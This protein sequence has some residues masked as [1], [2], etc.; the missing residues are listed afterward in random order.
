[1]S[2]LRPV[3]RAA[4][5]VLGFVALVSGVAGGLVRVGVEVPA[6]SAGIALHGTLLASA[7]FGT[8]ISLERAVA[9]GRLWAYAAPAASGIG[10]VAILFGQRPVGLAL[11]GLAGATFAA[12][13]GLIWLRQRAL[14]TGA[15]AVGALGLL[16]ANLAIAA[17]APLEVPVLGWLAFFALTIGGERLELSRLAP[18]PQGARAL[19]AAAAAALLAAALGAWVAPRAAAHATGAL[20]FVMA[21]WLL[22]YDI[23]TRTVHAAGLTRYIALC[24][25][26]GYAWLALGAVTLAATGGQVLERGI[27]DAALHAILIGFV[28]SMVF[29]HA[30][31]IFPAVLRVAIPYRPIL[32]LP[33]ALLHASLALRLAGDFL[34]AAP[35]RA[36]GAIGNAA[37]IALFIATAAGLAA[38]AA[39]GAAGKSIPKIES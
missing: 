15:L 38:S 37:A 28:F 16:E 34:G 32:Y 8:L 21:C 18:V 24:L 29:G 14:H 26:T 4:L 1:M 10:G 12:V 36:W 35:L 30:P 5:L 9:L 33:A 19:F 6:P 3:G 27:H 23:A 7:F 31:V 17:D 11:L 2:D 39:F 22:R 25:L 13:S 20:L